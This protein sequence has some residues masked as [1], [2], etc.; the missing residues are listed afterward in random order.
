MLNW[1]FTRGAEEQMHAFMDGFSNVFP[2]HR[3]RYFDERELENSKP[4]Y[5]HK[6]LSTSPFVF[7]RVDAVMKPLQPPT[8]HTMCSNANP[9]TSFLTVMA[10][11]IQSVLKVKIDLSG[12]AS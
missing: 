12:I 7:V 9:N 3:L 6:H 8:D 5:I 2:L 1:R 10:P 4:T 11:R